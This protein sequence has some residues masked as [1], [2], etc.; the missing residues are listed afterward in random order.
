[1][2]DLFND[3][4]TVRVLKKIKFAIKIKIYGE[5]EILGKN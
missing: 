3:I 1:M 4:L 5:N 2:I